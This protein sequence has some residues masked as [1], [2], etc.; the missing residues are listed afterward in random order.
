MDDQGFKMLF[1]EVVPLVKN[2]TDNF[3]SLKS[4]LYLS[5]GLTV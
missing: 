5:L 4:R 2:G 1:Q 3:T